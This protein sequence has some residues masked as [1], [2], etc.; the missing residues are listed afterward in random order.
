MSR[1]QGRLVRSTTSVL[2]TKSCQRIPR[3]IRWERMWKTLSFRR[4]SCRSVHV[5]EPYNKM[6]SI[7]VWYRR[8]FVCSWSRVCRQTLFIECRAVEAM[9]MRLIM[10]GWHLSPPLPIKP[11]W[12]GSMHAISSYHGNRPTHPRT[13]THTPTHRQDRLQYTA[14]QLARRVTSRTVVFMSRQL[15]RYCSQVTMPMSVRKS[16]SWLTRIYVGCYGNY[17]VPLYEHGFQSINQSINHLFAHK[18]IQN[19]QMQ[20][21]K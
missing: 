17:L 12:W 16:I 11:V 10:S 21:D 19:T 3:I 14:P 4:S 1:T 15:T 5:S 8:S 18:S 6:D 9:P 13:H 7:Q 2:L 20:Q